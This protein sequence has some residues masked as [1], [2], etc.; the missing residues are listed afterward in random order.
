LAELQTRFTAKYPDVVKARHE[1][2][3]L[4]EQR[5]ASKSGT[6][7][8]KEVPMPSSPY[9]NELR[10]AI[11]ESE[12]EIKALRSEGEGLKV[13]LADYRHRMEKGPQPAQQSQTL[14]REYEATKDRYNSLLKRQEEAWLGESMEQRQKGEQLRLIEPAIP[15]HKAAAPKRNR[16]IVI[17]FMLSLGLA[18]GLVVVREQLDTS[19]HKVDELRA[20]TRIP[21]LVSISR[22]ITK[23]DVRRRRRRLSLAVASAVLGLILVFCLSSLLVDKNEQLTQLVLRSGR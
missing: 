8:E 7:G 14:E 2:A 15:S 12:A 17:A 21:V 3:S 20:F 13:S 6:G 9:M 16:L 22:I 1:L 5:D 10:R 11:G 23:A 19:F 18:A 4:E